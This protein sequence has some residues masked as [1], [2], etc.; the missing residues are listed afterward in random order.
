MGDSR[1]RG[2]TCLQ[3]DVS[4]VQLDV[5]KLC[6][7]ARLDMKRFVQTVT[8]VVIVYWCSVVFRWT[9][10]SAI[11]SRYEWNRTVRVGLDSM[12]RYAAIFKCLYFLCFQRLLATGGIRFLDCP[13]CVWVWWY[14]ESLSEQC[15]TKHS[16]E[17]NQIYNFYA[18]E[19][20][21][22]L[23]RFWGHYFYTGPSL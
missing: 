19:D 7:L 12:S 20:K 8:D 21:D 17:F 18:V 22:E 13:V 6:V 4:L 23:I 11:M 15:L 3:N 14:A 16:R 9:A 2:N 1:L 5:I 10:T